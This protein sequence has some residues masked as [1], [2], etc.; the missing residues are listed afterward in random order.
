MGAPLQFFSPFFLK[1]FMA[2]AE[3]ILPVRDKTDIPANTI[4]TARRAEI[5]LLEQEKFKLCLV[6]LFLVFLQY[7]SLFY[8]RKPFTRLSKEQK[9]QYL[10][11]I[12]DFPLSKVRQG[13]WGI[14]IFVY[15]GYYTQEPTWAGLHYGG[16]LVGKL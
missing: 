11:K 2:F 5:L 1:I 7:F 16:P 10:K 4:E 15:W 6:K 12:E 3:R 8:F 9:I 14:K 13:F